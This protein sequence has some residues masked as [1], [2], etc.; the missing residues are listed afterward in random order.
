MIINPRPTSERLRAIDPEGCSCTGCWVGDRVPL[1]LATAEHL[2]AML[3]GSV[4]D[5]SNSRWQVRRTDDKQ[6]TVASSRHT[7]CWQVP[8][9]ADETPLAFGRPLADDWYSVADLQFAMTRA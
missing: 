5:C 1:E 4:A 7:I 2:A 6:V 9:K 8:L 3:H